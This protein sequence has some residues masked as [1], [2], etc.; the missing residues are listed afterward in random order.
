MNINKV[1]ML[2]FDLQAEVV[3]LHITPY[4]GQHTIITK[5]NQINIHS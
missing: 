1:A 2:S 3:H 5:P 4:P